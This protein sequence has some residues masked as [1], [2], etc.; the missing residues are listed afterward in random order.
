MN[1]LENRQ[2]KRQINQAGYTALDAPSMHLRESVTDRRPEGR[3]DG[4]TDGHTLLWRC[5]G[6]FEN[7]VR[8]GVIPKERQTYCDTENLETDERTLLKME[9]N[10]LLTKS[11][12]MGQ[13]LEKNK[14]NQCNGK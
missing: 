2:T 13:N 1:S 12:L 3:T 10:N 5:D 4:R 8:K 7:L 11:K 6:A 9:G 14:C